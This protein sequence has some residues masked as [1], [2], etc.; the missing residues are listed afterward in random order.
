M[1][2]AR[3]DGADCEYPTSSDVECDYYIYEIKGLWVGDYAATD[4]YNRRMIEL[5]IVEGVRK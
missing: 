3:D 2:W 5:G 1:G 4:A